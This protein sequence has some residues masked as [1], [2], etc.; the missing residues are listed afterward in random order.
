MQLVWRKSRLIFL[1]VIRREIWKYF[2]MGKKRDSYLCILCLCKMLNKCNKWPVQLVQLK[3][4]KTKGS[5]IRFL[6]FLKAVRHLKYLERKRWGHVTGLFYF[7]LFRNSELCSCR[8][9][10]FH[11][12]L[13]CIMSI[14]V[15]ML[16][17]QFYKKMF[18]FKFNFC[19]IGVGLRLSSIF[20]L[21]RSV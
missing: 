18:F 21:S 4:S 9:L 10:T 15:W 20:L 14:T 17:S 6:P 13:Y 3:I 5:S 7:S 12:T 8:F 11:L 16:E 2:A 1:N 19:V